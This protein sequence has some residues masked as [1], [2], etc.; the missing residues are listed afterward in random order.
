LPLIVLLHGY[1]VSA[2][3][4]DAY[5]KLSALVEEH[6]LLLVLA[7]GTVDAQGKSFWNASEDVLQLLWIERRRR[8]LPERSHQRDEIEAL[9]GGHAEL[10]RLLATVQLTP[11]R[12][13]LGARHALGVLDDAG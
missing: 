3:A 5:F 8:C 11:P 7:E 4:Q 10:E 2:A 9:G 1:D 13:L 6:K 12:G